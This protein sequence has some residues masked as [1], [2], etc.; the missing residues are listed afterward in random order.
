M[1]KIKEGTLFTMLIPVVDADVSSYTPLEIWKVAQFID[2]RGGRR[3]A[4]MQFEDGGTTL[5]P[6]TMLQRPVKPEEEI[7]YWKARVEHLEKET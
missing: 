2:Y 4:V 1:D 5:W 3:L 6:L 7:A